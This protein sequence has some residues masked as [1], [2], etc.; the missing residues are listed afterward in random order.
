MDNVSSLECLKFDSQ[1][2]VLCK[3]SGGEDLLSSTMVPINCDT[4]ITW[5]EAYELEADDSETDDFETDESEVDESEADVFETDE[6]ETD[7]SDTD[8]SETDDSETEKLISG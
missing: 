4:P 8:D 6:C 5:S 3:D 1:S 2:K 7:Y